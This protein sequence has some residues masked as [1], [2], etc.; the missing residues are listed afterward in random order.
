MMTYQKILH[1]FLCGIKR[2]YFDSQ[3]LIS[4]VNYTYKRCERIVSLPETENV[5]TICLDSCSTK[6]IS[7]P[8]KVITFVTPYCFMVPSTPLHPYNL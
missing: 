7:R 8:D 4:S 5:S 3:K 6:V 2:K 1:I